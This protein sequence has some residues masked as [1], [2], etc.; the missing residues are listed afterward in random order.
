MAQSLL[1]DPWTLAQV[2]AAVAPYAGRLPASDL[3]WM[4]DQLLQAL[5]SDR[6]TA[7]AL[8]AAHPRAVDQ[9]GEVAW[10]DDTTEDAATR[11]RGAEPQPTSTRAR[12]RAR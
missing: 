6:D 7:R 10:D 4:R 2:D 8:R 12:G 1:E 11:V 5:R 3:K 9:S